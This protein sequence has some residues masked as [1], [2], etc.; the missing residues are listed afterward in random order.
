[1]QNEETKAERV[2]SDCACRRDTRGGILEFELELRDVV[3]LVQRGSFTQTE[4]IARVQGWQI[5][6][7][8]QGETPL[9]VQARNV[10]LEQGHGPTCRFGEWAGAVEWSDTSQA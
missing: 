2:N 3:G 10:A 5:P 8:G 6:D 4:R 7:G 1:M 9:Y